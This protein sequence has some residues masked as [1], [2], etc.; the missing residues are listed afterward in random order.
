MFHLHPKHWLLILF[1][2]LLLGCSD[3]ET[4]LNTMLPPIEVTQQQAEGLLH[5]QATLESIDEVDALL[6]IESKVLIAEATKMLEEKYPELL[7]PKLYFRDQAAFISTKFEIAVNDTLLEGEMVGGA[8]VKFDNKKMSILPAFEFIHVDQVRN[9]PWY[10]NSAFLNLANEALRNYLDNANSLLT[11]HPDLHIPVD[12]NIYQT[13]NLDTMLK[14]NPSFK[15]M[16]GH[17][18]SPR[19][20]ANVE[21]HISSLVPYI[22]KDEI[23]LALDIGTGK[24]VKTKKSELNTT[25]STR[26]DNAGI[27]RLV[28]EFERAFSKKAGHLLRSEPSKISL[29]FSN[30]F[31]SKLVSEVFSSVELCLTDEINQAPSIIKP[32]DI[33]PFKNIPVLDCTPTRDCT[34][35]DSHC[36]YTRDRRDCNK[37]LSYRPWG[38]CWLRG[39]DP[40]CEAAKVAVNTAME[41]E[42]TAC[43]LEVGKRKLGCETIKSLDKIGCEAN[44]E[45]LNAVRRIGKVGDIKGDLKYSGASSVCVNKIDLNQSLDKAIVDIRVSSNLKTNGNLTF[46]PHDVGYVIACITPWTRKFRTSVVIP[47]QSISIPGEVSY[48]EHENVL[49]LTIETSPTKMDFV[50]VPS[51]VR[52]IFDQNPDLNV[53]CPA[54]GVANIVENLLSKLGHGSEDPAFTGEF[55]EEIPA[56]TKI[57]TFNPQRMKIGNTEMTGRVVKEKNGLFIIV[58]D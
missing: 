3:I 4:K 25:T 51:P 7:E 39:N 38:G 24:Q 18:I 40:V 27:E 49:N 30:S 57:V 31:I 52:T 22:Q 14:D 53:L 6:S 20:Q 35:S 44:K 54:L 11:K 42:A 12:L 55:E 5:A 45:W 56:D 46:R 16:K 9:G 1:S 48:S 15:E 36:S 34:F 10:T 50:I 32:T 43:R 41:I 19:G 28:S 37:C 58:N 13:L 21:I 17:A 23:R 2:T 33:K 29:G 8:S 26:L 47:N